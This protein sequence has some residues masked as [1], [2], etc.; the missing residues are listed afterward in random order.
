MYIQFT[1][2]FVAM[3]RRYPFQ[4][5]FGIHETEL[6]KVIGSGD[7]KAAEEIIESTTDPTVLDEGR[8]ENIPLHMVLN[9][10]HYFKKCRNL[11]LAQLLV[12]KGASPNRRIPYGDM[13]GASPSPFEELVVYYEVLKAHATGVSDTLCEEL[14]MFFETDEL[15]LEF[16]TNTVDLDNTKCLPN[17]EN[18]KKLI[19]QTSELIDIFLRYGGDPNVLTTFDHKSLFH[20]VVEHDVDLAK[21]FLETCR[22][23]VNLSDVHG[24]T[25]FMDSILI[26]T[27]ENSLSLYEAMCDTTEFLDIDTCDCSGETA[28]FRAVFAGAIEIANKLC[29]DGARF[30]TEVCLSLVPVSTLSVC[31]ELRESDGVLHASLIEKVSPMTTPLLAPLL[32]DSPVRLRYASVSIQDSSSKLF[33][34]HKHLADKIIS[35]AIS[36]L[37][38]IGCFSHPVVASEVISVL[39]DKNL[40]YI[41]DG[42]VSPIDL[43]TLM[44]GQVSAGLRQLC[45]RT[46]FDHS[47]MASQGTDKTWHKSVPIFCNNCFEGR[48]TK[49]KTKEL[50]E[51]LGL[52]QPFQIFFDIEAD[53]YQMCSFTMSYQCTECDRACSASEE[54]FIDEDDTDSD[55]SY[56]DSDSLLF[57]SSDISEESSEEFDDLSDED[58]SGSDEDVEEVLKN[59]EGKKQETTELKKIKYE[60]NSSTSESDNM[61]VVVETFCEDLAEGVAQDH[62]AVCCDKYQRFTDES[63]TTTASPENLTASDSISDSLC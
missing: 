61:R 9:N 18:V 46:I 58:L 34:P 13:E 39:D 27:P 49:K 43:L 48:I 7:F 30:E 57:F 59:D 19:E 37:I 44:F 16:L 25:P 62:P 28:L 60:P 22:V 14:E 52:P 29:K 41:M 38:D 54:S 21:R 33:H 17:L 15:I 3:A 42:D 56:A 50:V 2:G 11:R 32:A 63:T 1:T 4:G 47:F 53:K 51:S 36:P 55:L 6:T 20:W 23:N 24:S 5:Q 26:N 40:D 31:R 45:V 12:Q 35:A 10:N 8:Y